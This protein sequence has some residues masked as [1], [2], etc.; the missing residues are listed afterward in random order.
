MRLTYRLSAAAAFS[1]VIF[2][3]APARAQLQ[4][5]MENIGFGGDKPE[6]EYR[7]R[8]PLV[9][10]PK[11]DLPAPEQK[12]ATLANPAWP[13]DPDVLARK[14]KEDE[15]R[16]PRVASKDRD[17]RDLN[18]SPDELR[19]GRLA[20]GEVGSS[21]DYYHSRN[22][23]GFDKGSDG[24]GRINPDVLRQ[25]GEAFRGVEGPPLKPG[26]EPKRKYLTDPPVG[27]R[28]PAA[29]APVV[30]TAE[31]KIDVEEESSPYAFFKKLTGDDE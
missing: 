4:E 9:V 30:A 11:M 2:A 14:A 25:Q 28:A 13:K 27:A 26:E 12:A 1:A 17:A 15:E 19:K 16:K 3:A 8:A 31:K 5:L 22:S 20:G 29:G 7:E 23:N 18:L 10:P 24:Y 6:I 21:A